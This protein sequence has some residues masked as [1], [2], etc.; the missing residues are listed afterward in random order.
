MASHPKRS[1]RA[2]I[3][4]KYKQLKSINK[5]L[6]EEELLQKAIEIVDYQAKE[7]DID[8]DSLFIDK[9]EKK[10][11][12]DLLRKYLKDYTIETVSDKNT[13]R[14]LIYLEILNLRLQTTLNN[15]HSETQASPKELVDT[16]HKNNREILSVKDILGISRSKD[17]AQSKDAY[18]YLQMLKRKFKRWCS[19]NQAT[20][21]LVCSHCGKSLLLKI[22]PGVWDSQKHPFF[23]D[24]ILGNQHLIELY[25]QE[26]LTKEDLAKIF[27]TSHDYIDWLVRRGWRLNASVTEG[28]EESEGSKNTQDS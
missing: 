1:R 5:N 16:I 28:S 18:S 4:G 8:I 11:A 24:R 27:E 14:Q 10:L 26:K 12:V 19:E 17:Q 6:T 22:K 21:Y 3:E 23:R 20:R 9:A 7:K 2:L 25:K 15:V 13:L